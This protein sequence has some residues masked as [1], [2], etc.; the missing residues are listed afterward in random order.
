[1]TLRV[2]TPF[3]VNV[4]CVQDAISVA[5]DN[6]PE[7]V[8]AS[9]FNRPAVMGVIG[10]E[11]PYRPQGADLVAHFY[12]DVATYPDIY[13]TPEPNVKSRVLPEVNGFTWEDMDM[14]EYWHRPQREMHSLD[15]VVVAPSSSW[16]LVDEEPDYYADETGYKRPYYFG[17]EWP[18]YDSIET[19]DEV[20]DYM[21][22]RIKVLDVE[23]MVQAYRQPLTYG[24]TEYFILVRHRAQPKLTVEKVA[25]G[26]TLTV[27]QRQVIEIAVSIPDA[28]AGKFGVIISGQRITI[29]DAGDYSLFYWEHKDAHGY[30]GWVKIGKG[31]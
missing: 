28:L 17:W 27:G 14:D 26:E 13:A 8:G 30:V 24:G 12:G 1:M 10:R 7:F 21:L 2:L 6:L 22:G 31:L 4:T 15:I 19:P 29:Q 16:D 20:F 25:T 3:D 5:R 9:L 18:G 11:A 23:G